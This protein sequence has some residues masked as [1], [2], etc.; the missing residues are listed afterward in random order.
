MKAFI[1]ALLLLTTPAQARSSFIP[2]PIG[3]SCETIKAAVKTVGLENLKAMAK[4]Y[5]YHVT[6]SQRREALKCLKDT[7]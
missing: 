2:T 1:L 3:Y 4:K 6:A 5:G 7:K